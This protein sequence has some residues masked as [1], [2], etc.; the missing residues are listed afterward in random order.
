[1]NRPPSSPASGLLWKAGNFTPCEAIPL[2]DRGLRYG[3]AF[4][5]SLAV[6]NGKV[7][8][9]SAHL[10]R[11]QSAASTHH[12]PVDPAAW[13]AVESALLSLAGDRPFFARL[14]LSA[15][16]GGPNSPVTAPR[17]VCY[18]EE[19]SLTPPL[20]P[21][22]LRESPLPYLPMPG[23]WKRSTYWPNLHAWEE[24]RSHG[25]DEALLFSPAGEL[26]SAAMANL[27]ARIDGQWLTPPVSS[28]ARRG[29]I[30]EWVMGQLNV[31]ERP[32]LRG[33]LLH[34][35]ECFLTSS[36]HGILPVATLQPAGDAVTLRMPRCNEEAARLR[37]AFLKIC[38]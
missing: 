7:E 12:W 21:Y 8:F 16:D 15:G 20:A 1:M 19:R 23:G 28:G 18:G 31:S 14:W 33:D 4:F 36:W 27:F 26:I 2:S 5:E 30:R 11:L 38:G 9:L 17:L 35:E 10:E 32:L 25:A 24:A 34:L 6:R 22:H 29:V 3:M 13:K 37:Q